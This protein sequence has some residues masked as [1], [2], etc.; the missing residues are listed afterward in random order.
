MAFSPQGTTHRSTVTGRRGMIASAH[1]LA[2]LAGLRILME[3]GNAIDAAIATAAALNVV[4]PYMSGIGGVGYLHIYSA[5]EKEH[6]IVDYVG[7]TP[8][9]ADIRLYDEPKQDR[10]PLSPLVPGACGGWLLALERYGSMDAAQVFAPAIEYAEQ[11]Y[12]L[13]VKNSL[14]YAAAAPDLLRFKTG[15]ETYL[16]DGQAPQPGEVVVQKDLA[17]T[18]RK[19]AAEG[20]DIYYKG[21]IAD[22]ITRYMEQ[23]GG[24]LTSADL[25]DFTPAIVDPISIDYRGRQIFAPPLP[26][27]AIQ[28]LET[29]AIMEGFDVADMGHNTAET[30][31]RFI[32][33]TKLAM[34]DRIAYAAI[35]APPTAGLLSKEFAAARRALIGE[36]AQFTAGER[37]FP[38]SPAGEVP[39]GDPGQ[40]M[41]ECTTHFDAI[42]ADGNAVSCTQSLG[43]GFGSAMVVPGTGITLNNFMRWFDLEPTSPNAIG[44]AIKNEMCVSPAQVWDQH[45]LRLLIGTPGSYGILQTTP[46][47]I[48]NVLDH[49]LSI[50][51]AIEAPRVKTGAPG[52]A[53]DAESRI[54]REVFAELERR[55]H[56]FH[57]LGDW[58]AGV[59]GGQ[60]IA[61]DP[62]T[63]SFMGGA[64]PRRDGYALGW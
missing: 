17:E 63:G 20:P 14:F 29:L 62:D 15:G 39:A 34:A 28:Y 12:A 50:Q 25:A 57:D 27:Q 6:K 49:Q 33:T 60:G 48:M 13:T 64:D 3:G 32:E 42:D 19:V 18:F 9:A 45:G 31:H 1:P 47:M 53:V 2:S 61:V 38:G 21:A 55:G 22:A 24:L 16:L 43:S 36:R 30:L 10:G 58:S 35:D 23:T 56:Q 7:L 26:C 52:Y 51:A 5:R 54:D 40:W 11:G 8:Q 44:P 41:Q 59:G 37:L 4:E 46:Q